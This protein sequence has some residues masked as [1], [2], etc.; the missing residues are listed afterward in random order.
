[1]DKLTAISEAIG[2]VSANYISI[3]EE[4][5]NNARKYGNKEC[6]LSVEHFIKTISQH[7]YNLNQLGLSVNSTAK[8]LKKLFPGRVITTTGCK[9]CTYILNSVGHKYCSH[10]KNVYEYS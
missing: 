3:I 10:C 5:G 9:P 7:T 8:L 2:I 6:P 4:A 1:M